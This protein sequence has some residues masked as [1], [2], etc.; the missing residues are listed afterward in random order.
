MLTNCK[1]HTPKFPEKSEIFGIAS[2][3]TLTENETTIVLSDYF[4]DVKPVDSAEAKNFVIKFSKDKKNITLTPIGDSIPQLS[5][6]KIWAKG[7]PYSILLKKSRKIKQPLTYKPGKK[8][9]KSVSVAGD[10]NDWNPA[11]TPMELKNNLWQTELL[12]N[13]GKYSYQLVVDG[14]WMLDPANPD[15]VSNNIGGYNSLLIAGKTDTAKLPRLYTEKDAGENITVGFENNLDDVLIFWQNFR[16]GDDFVSVNDK[17]IEIR[18]PGKAKKTERTYIRVFGYNKYGVANDLLIPLQNG[19]VINNVAK[20]KPDDPE[21]TILYFL[22][23]DRFANGNP[24]NDE[25]V[26]DPEV[27]QR[28]N[29]WG[30]DLAGIS[31]KIKDGYFTELGINTIWISPIIQNPKKA[32]FEFPAPHRKFS[33]YHGYWP[34][35]FANVDTRFG[36]NDEF[37]DLIKTAH[38]KNIKVLLDWVANHV[39]EEHPMYKKHPDWVTQ[40]DLPDGRK[41]IRLWDEQRLTTWFDTFLPTLDFSKPEVTETMTDSAVLWIEKYKLDGFRHDATKHIPEVFWRTL[42]R[43]LKDQVMIPENKRLY[44]IGETFGSRDL[45]GSYVNSGELDAQFDFNLYFDARSVFAINADPFTKLKNSLL[46]SFAYFG[47]HHL[48]GNITGN[49]DLPRF[50]ALAG[51]ALKFNEDDKEAGWA[52]DIEVPDPTGYKKLSMLTAF[53]MTIPGVPVIYYGDEIGMPGA[54]DPDNRRPMKFDNLAPEEQKVKQTAESLIKLRKER[55]S[56][57]YGDMEVLKCTSKIFVYIRTYFDELTVAAFNKDTT[58]RTVE[59]ELPARYDGKKLKANFGSKVTVSGSKVTV[60][61][62]ATSFD[63]ITN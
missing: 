4:A 44:Q 9:C 18:I 53:N 3:V 27:H 52:R 56:L 32:Y 50:I 17:N 36:S 45:I 40:L 57:I 38:S 23:V 49:Q 54:G 16:L 51:G 42:T 2:P 39:H 37:A 28:A 12:L 31:K 24:H 43:K 30:G 19:K 63:I 58:A 59:F 29:Y 15:S 6:L 34:V 14:K 11:K 60:E 22:M 1:N 35:S 61:L 8:P 25:P 55:L 46:E 5:E 20:L 33:G 26:N 47:S 62:P 13:P 41:N 7:F 21:A 48:M 10:L